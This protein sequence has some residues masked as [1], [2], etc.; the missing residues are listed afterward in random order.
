VLDKALN[1]AVFAGVSAWERQ[2]VDRVTDVVGA[3]STGGLDE[4]ADGS[5]VDAPAPESSTAS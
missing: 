3:A 2:V 5:V 4:E 1:L